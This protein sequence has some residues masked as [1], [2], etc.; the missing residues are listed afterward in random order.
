MAFT[1]TQF[2]EWSWSHS[3]G[4]L[5]REC[6]RRYY[7]HYYASHNGWLKDASE[8]RKVA[9]RL[10]QM[11]NLFLHFGDAVHQVADMHVR[12]WM[13]KGRRFTYEELQERVRNMMNQAVLESRDVPQW[14][15]A[16]KKRK[17]FVEQYYNGQ[18]PKQL[19]GIIKE[20]MTVCLNNLL[21]SQSLHDM[22]HDPT[23]EILEME[24]LNTVLIGGNKVYVKLDVLYRCRENEEPR[25]VIVDWK[26]GQEDASI[27]DQLCLYAYYL[28]RHL[29]IPLEQIEIRTEYLLTGECKRTFVIEEQLAEVEQ[30]IL[31]SVR[32]MKGVL[33][34]PLTNEPLPEAS[35]GGPQ[36]EKS[37]RFCNYRQVCDLKDSGSALFDVEEGS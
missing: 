12:Q 26:T 33:A 5:F 11:T 3:R 6:P 29:G 28:N 10:K 21:T 18:L 14:W 20:R 1:I 2:P 34:D 7:Y 35:F 15:E 30:R 31:A 27:D 22:T 4:Q 8:Q 19:V 23:V 36:D 37:C 9:Y 24:Q 17:M 13:S 32:E 16:P 25:Y